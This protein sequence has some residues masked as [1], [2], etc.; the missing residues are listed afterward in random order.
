MYLV[1]SIAA[2]PRFLSVGLMIM[3]G[4]FLREFSAYVCS[5]VRLDRLEFLYFICSVRC[6]CLSCF[7]QCVILSSMRFDARGGF[8]YLFLM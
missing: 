3:F 4:F 7:S 1:R 6:A 2:G 8:Q 5:G